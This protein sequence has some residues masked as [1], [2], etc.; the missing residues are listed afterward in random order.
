[1]YKIHHPMCLE[2][3]KDWANKDITLDYAMYICNM[4]DSRNIAWIDL[5][6]EMA[7]PVGL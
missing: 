3:I 4:V 6:R 7:A 5:L 2:A 1:M